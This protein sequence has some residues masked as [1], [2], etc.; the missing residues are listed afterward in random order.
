MANEINQV[1]VGSTTY[2]LQDSRVDSLVTGVSSVNGKTGDVTIT[3]PSVPVNATT[4]AVAPS[5]C[6]SNG[7]YYVSSGTNSLTDKDGNPFLQ[8][9]TAQNF[10]ILATAYSASWIQQ[11]AT[12]FRSEH[13]YIRRCENG[14]WKPWTKIAQT[15]EIPSV[16]TKV[17]ELS[18]DSKF[19]TADQNM[20]I[21]WGGS[22]NSNPSWMLAWSDSGSTIQGVAPSTI[23]AGN[24]TKLN[25]QAASYYAAA[26]SV[27]EKTTYEKSA[28]LACGSN[29]LVCLGKFGA[30]DTNITIELNST[31][32]QTYHATIVIWSQNVVANGTGGTVGCYVYD[33]AD[34]HI[35]PLISVFRP[36]G[37]ASRQIEVYASL[38]G[39]S[40]NLVHVQGVA[41]SDGGMTDVLTSVSSIPTSIAGKTKVTPINVLTTNFASK[42]VATTSAAGLL[43][44]TDKT[45]LDNVSSINEIDLWYDTVTDLTVNEYGINWYDSFDMSGPSGSTLNGML[46]MNVPIV[47]GSNISITKNDSGK[48]EIEFMPSSWN[49]SNTAF[50]IA[51]Y[52]NGLYEFRISV[53]TKEGNSSSN[54]TNNLSTFAY[55][56]GGSYSQSPTCTAKNSSGTITQYYISINTAGGVTLYQASGT[57]ISTP[58]SRTIYYRKIANA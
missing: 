3:I 32:S 44:T 27:L 41:L 14:T 1:K 4:S 5:A 43:S 55:W 17:S 58:L 10:R 29:G 30:Y 37:S 49:V 31:T 24:A 22:I 21:K 35:T 51:D 12:D 15:S 40:K 50:G 52:G 18:N 6:T 7:F 28:E 25:G 42:D 47:A 48:A 9:H 46:T 45:K 16:P 19:V 54:I 39:W 34:N 38:P 2:T 26:S 20:T 56:E 53:T 57:T 8:Y 23:T 36:Y 13:V 33:D 11:I